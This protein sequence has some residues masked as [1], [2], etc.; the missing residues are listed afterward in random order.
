[1]F[2]PTVG[3]VIKLVE[4]QKRDIEKNGKKLDVSEP[5]NYDFK[6]LSSP[7]LQRVVLVGGFG[8]SNYLFSRLKSWCEGFKI[9]AFCP[10]HP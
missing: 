6:A 9:R 3:E 2:E 4:A 10:E 7:R 5:K 1:M 8:D